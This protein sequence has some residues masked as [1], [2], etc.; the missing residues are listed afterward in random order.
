M[1]KLTYFTY[2]EKERTIKGLILFG[3]LLLISF[4]SCKPDAVQGENESEKPI[5]SFTYENKLKGLV[6][7]KNL[8][9]NAKE[10]QWD[11][12]D[13]NYSVDSN[14][15]HTYLKNGAYAVKLTATNGN[16]FSSKLDTINVTDL[17]LPVADF[18]YENLG[19]GKIQFRNKS[20][21][22]EQFTWDFGDGNTSSEQ[23]PLHTYTSNGEFI[24]KL[25]IK[26]ENG[27]SEKTATIA[28]DDLNKPI[29]E[30]SF[31]I[32][33]NTVSFTNDSKYGETYQW[34]FGDGNSSTEQNPKHSYTNNGDY[35]VTLTV[36]NFLGENS[37]TKTINITGIINTN[38]RLLFV[39]NNY[40]ITKQFVHAI[41]ASTGNIKWS[42]DS[43]SGYIRGGLTLVNNVLYFGDDDYLYAANADNGAILWKF[44]LSEGMKSSPLVHNGVV[45][46]GTNEKKVYAINASSG[47][48]KWEFETVASV[49]A[50]PIIHNNVLYVGTNNTSDR[51]GTFY[52][53]NISDGSLKWSRGSYFGS[54]N[55][56][57][58]VIGSNVYFG[59]TGGFHILN[60]N[61]GSLIKHFYFKI[62]ESTPIVQGNTVFGVIDGQYLASMS[63]TSGDPNWTFDLKSIFYNTYT[64]PI[65]VNNIL[66]VNGQNAVYAIN[67]SNGKLVWQYQSNDFNAKELTYANNIIYSTDSKGSDYTSPTELVALDASNGKVL[68]K[69]SINGQLGDITVIDNSGKVYYSQESGQQ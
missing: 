26:N 41:D 9:E 2:S 52:A 35:T 39:A 5:A 20:V 3:F 44:S 29:A 67:S 58:V 33:Q 19:K 46:I 47:A 45:Y 14:P 7:F 18:T 24:V 10:F 25:N 64:S 55:T 16:N 1:K 59:G 60:I 49:T 23:E 37:Q 36:K 15:S 30:F 17:N 62:S 31:S 13:G 57:A 42:N 53:I 28:F 12:G 11:F 51:G 27:T 65:L 32:V 66:Y 56:K 61:D 68:F 22:A 50:S 34:N 69:K 38:N 63:L 43:Y 8:S 21:F 54:M 48:K 6:Q 4:N 40:G